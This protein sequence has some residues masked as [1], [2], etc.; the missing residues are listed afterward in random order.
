MY[1]S[2]GKGRHLGYAGKPVSGIDTETA[3]ILIKKGVI[4]ESLSEAIGNAET[5]VEDVIPVEPVIP[6]MSVKVEVISPTVEP[7][8][9][10]VPKK[11]PKKKAGKKP[12]YGTK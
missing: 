9:K 3:K 6:D 4:V 8:A 12:V 5:K 1:Y 11:A 10:K 7:K 2:T